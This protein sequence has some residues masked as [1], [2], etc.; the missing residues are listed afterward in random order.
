LTDG[1][2]DSFSFDRRLVP[3]DEWPVHQPVVGRISIKTLREARAL[4]AGGELGAIRT[5][6]ATYSQQWLTT[7]LE[8]TGNRQAAWRQDPSK[9]GAAGCIGDI[10]SHA[11]NLAAFVTGLEVEA[12]CAEISSRA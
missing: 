7:A 8:K 11:F 6:R 9:G 2:K 10:G 3:W 5:V 1:E 12:V 4:V